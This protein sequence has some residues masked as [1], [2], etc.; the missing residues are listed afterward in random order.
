M[1]N[2]LNKIE[3]IKNIFDINEKIKITSSIEE[4]IKNCELSQNNDAIIKK[5]K[6]NFLN[7]KNINERCIISVDH[8]S[9]EE[10]DKTFTYCKINFTLLLTIKD[11]FEMFEKIKNN[12]QKI[13]IKTPLGEYICENK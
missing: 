4:L 3:K 1:N 10:I 13:E 12:I 11:F 7:E 5:I 6:E 8:I 2:F 9:Y